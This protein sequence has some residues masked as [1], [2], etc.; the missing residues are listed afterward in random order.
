MQIDLV[1]PL[2]IDSV[3][4]D[5]KKVPFRQVGDF[6]YLQV[7][8]QKQVSKKQISIYYSGKPVESLHAPWDGGIV[9]GKQIGRAH[10]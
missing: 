7:N 3:I 8:K 9:T 6:W 2:G 5:G 1:F 10:V 4:Q